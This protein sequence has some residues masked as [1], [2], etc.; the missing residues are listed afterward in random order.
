[1]TKKQQRFADFYIISL[2]MSDSARK[3]GY[4]EDSA[5]SI[6]FELMKKPEMRAY[7]DEK[8]R[9]MS[10]SAEE[11]K[12]LITDIA[13][14]SLNDYFIVKKI[15]KP[16]RVEVG[17]KVLI[18][19]LRQK[20]SFEAEFATEAKL[21]S[22]DLVAHDLAQKQREL[23]IIRYQIELK[24]NKNATRI[25]DGPTEWVESAEL[26]MVKLVQDK[27]KGKIKSISY[28]Q[29]GPKIEMYSADA[30]LLNV[31]KIHGL[32]EKDNEQ[33]KPVAKQVM[34]VNGKEIEF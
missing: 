8:M 23:E 29:Y 22:D 15:E 16:T 32:F 17:L 30:A 4:S 18:K 28:T 14:S 12:K 19:Q 11:T 6:G 13:R 31:A 33:L 21:A 25:V 9:E 34:I 24:R 27:E 7:I 3:A 26:D 5:G 10:L 2:N 20:I 1:M